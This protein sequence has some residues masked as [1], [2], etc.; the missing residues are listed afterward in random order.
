MHAAEVY[1]GSPASPPLP[2]LDKNERN[3]LRSEGDESGWT[4]FAG[5]R[6]LQRYAAD[7]LRSTIVYRARC[8]ADAERK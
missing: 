7:D 3:V 4:L 6:V 8:F 1:L 2:F 5:E